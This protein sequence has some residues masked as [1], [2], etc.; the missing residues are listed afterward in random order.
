MQRLAA[1][2]FQQYIAHTDAFAMITVPASNASKSD[3]LAFWRGGQPSY[4]LTKVAVHLLSM[5]PS[6]GQSERLWAHL[7]RQTVPIR[8]ALLPQT[9]AALMNIAMNWRWLYPDAPLQ[10]DDPR[11]AHRELSV[12]ETPDAAPDCVQEEADAD[13][14]SDDVSDGS[15]SSDSGS[16]APMVP[17]DEWPGAEGD[18]DIFEMPPAPVVDEDMFVK[19]VANALGLPL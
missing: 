5:R 9:K 1:K 2:A 4:A 15:S 12:V 3:V 8:N 10:S 18:D 16:E 13:A 19:D 11:N 14:K 17:E 7:S 6:Q